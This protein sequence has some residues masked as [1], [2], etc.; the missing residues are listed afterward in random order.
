MKLIFI[1]LFLASCGE[2]SKLI[3][4]APEEKFQEISFQN[5]R[6]NLLE[7]KCMSCHKDFSD[8]KK[9]LEYIDLKNP[10]NSI[11]YLVVK[12][13]SMPPRGRP[14]TSLE[15]EFVRNY[16]TSF[17]KPSEPE[18]PTPLPE[19][20]FAELREKILV[21][22]CLGCH[23]RMGDEENLKRWVNTEA[24]LE[25]KLYVRTFDRSMPKGG[26]PLSEEEMK[27]IKDYVESF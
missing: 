18:I 8:E 27:L 7:T 22:K 5:F 19:T 20:G 3:F 12:D 1:L 16:V 4:S 2:R 9:L 11:L 23:K 10:D 13:G 21:P 17:Q 24:P 25:S 6:A 14:L 15:L 26:E